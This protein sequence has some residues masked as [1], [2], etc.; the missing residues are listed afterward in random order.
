MKLSKWSLYYQPLALD[1]FDSFRQEFR[2]SNQLF[3]TP[4]YDNALLA[5]WTA[6]CEAMDK[7]QTANMQRWLPADIYFNMS[8]FSSV[9]FF[10][11]HIKQPLLSM[12][13]MR[14]IRC[15][16]PTI[17]GRVRNE[18]TPISVALYLSGVQPSDVTL[19]RHLL[20]TA[21]ID[22]NEVTIYVD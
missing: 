20:P 13:D 6:A 1:N 11:L 14:C 4:Q 5:M 21:Q 8:A 2:D 22:G 19:L 16:V 18:P 12:L 15:S 3:Y 9:W 10:S 17:R 7:I